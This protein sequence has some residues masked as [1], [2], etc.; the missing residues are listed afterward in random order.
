MSRLWSGARRCLYAPAV[1]LP[2]ALHVVGAYDVRDT[3]WLGIERAM[4]RDYAPPRLTLS[5]VLNSHHVVL[6]TGA[7]DLAADLFT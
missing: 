3:Q 4:R 6:S 2:F 5:S 1:C 7:A